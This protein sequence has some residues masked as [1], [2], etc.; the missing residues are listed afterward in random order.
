MT[1]ADY[2][3]DAARAAT[4][5]NRMLIL[6]DNNVFRSLTHRNC[7][8]EPNRFFQEV[9]AQGLI[10]PY[11]PISLALTPFSLLE[12]IGIRAPTP[13]L[14]YTRSPIRSGE[15]DQV[16]LDEERRETI[17]GAIDDLLGQAINFYEQCPAISQANLK[18]RAVEQRGYTKPTA[19]GFFD[20]YVTNVLADVNARRHMIAC[21]AADAVFKFNFPHDLLPHFHEQF[22]RM[23]F[24]RDEIDNSA[25]L[26]RVMKRIWDVLYTQMY[27]DSQN[28]NRERLAQAQQRMAIAND[29][30]F[31]DCELVHYLCVGYVVGQNRSPVIGFTTDDF[32]TVEMR[33]AVFKATAEQYRQSILQITN[34]T[35]EELVHHEQGTLVRCGSDAQLLE[36]VHVKDIQPIDSSAPDVS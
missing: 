35:E 25:G 21:L 4:S 1:C 22:L 19:L 29:H 20:R 23:L 15:K 28:F 10:A 9:R 16:K 13:A 26:F 24:S 12:A 11:A 31:L 33:I 2:R 30:D 32:K 27:A 5:A 17:D 14:F 8:G 18:A 7:G 3:Q 36:F 6:L 34:H